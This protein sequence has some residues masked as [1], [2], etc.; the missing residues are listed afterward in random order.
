MVVKFIRILL[1]GLII[2]VS[3]AAASAEQ[4]SCSYRQSILALADRLLADLDVRNPSIAQLY[5][6]DAAYLK[7]YYGQMSGAEIDGMLDRLMNT[8]A[9]D[10]NQFAYAYYMSKLGYEPGSARMGKRLDVVKANMFDPTL[11]RALARAGRYDLVVGMMRGV[12]EWPDK[13]YLIPMALPFMDRPPEER[14]RLADLAD[15]GGALALAGELYASLPDYDGWRGYLKRHFE[16]IGYRNLK[17]SFVAFSAVNYGSPPLPDP[18]NRMADLLYREFVQKIAA[19]SWLLP[20]SA[21]LYQFSAQFRFE[22]V[23]G[24]RAAQAI[25]DAYDRGDL[26]PESPIER[27][28]LLTYHA[29]AKAAEDPQ[30]IIRQMQSV[31]IRSRHYLQ[32]NTGD[33]LDTMLAS[34]AIGPW[35][36]G[37]TS[38]FPSVPALASDKLKANWPQWRKMAE[39]I[40]SGG[41]PDGLDKNLARRGMAA[42]LLYAKG[43]ETRLLASIAAESNPVFRERLEADF[44][45]RYDRLCDSSLYFPGD[46]FFLRDTTIYRFDALPK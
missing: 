41:N 37:E 24:K 21:L 15:S 30:I 25:K 33:I 10:A 18:K 26:R 11:I 27:G 2:A 28:W 1:T 8:W 32:G 12:Q 42:D 17:A 38:A 9:D 13:R 20:E 5:G 43:D 29:L 31:H 3:P 39:V 4:K 34:E 14:K 22:P 16:E 40:K 7:L 46:A 35:L 23:Y 45:T 19:S 44:M 6:R 36:R